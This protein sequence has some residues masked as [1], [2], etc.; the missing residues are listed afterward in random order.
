MKS[1]SGTPARR[2]SST[3][4]VTRCR[5]RLEIGPGSPNISGLRMCTSAV[6]YSISSTWEAGEAKRLSPTPHLATSKHG[7]AG[8]TAPTLGA[9]GRDPFV[10]DHRGRTVLCVDKSDRA[11]AVSASVTDDMVSWKALPDIL[12][13]PGQA[14]VELSSLHPL[15]GGYVLWF[16]DYGKDLAGFRAAYALSDDP[17]HF[18]ADS[19]R[20]F[21]F[22][23]DHPDAVPSPELPVSKPLP[24][25]IELIAC[26]ERRWLVCY[27]RWHGDRN[28]LFFGEI[29]W[30]GPNAVITEITS[31]A[32]LGSERGATGRSGR[33]RRQRLPSCRD[34]RMNDRLPAR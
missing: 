23:T 18:D 3:G 29:D 22:H 32:Q 34:R 28:R 13:I 27:F 20:E 25:S 31:L 14:V 24:L 21:E 6:R 19:I 5:L 10:F 8:P 2:I 33:S 1:R 7:H 12:T 17:L 11:A 4:S 16:N 15:N 30:S 9:P 26:G